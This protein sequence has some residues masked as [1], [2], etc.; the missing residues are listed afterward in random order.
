M[1]RL[2]ALIFLASLGCTRVTADDGCRID[3]NTVPCG[4]ASVASSAY[5]LDCTIWQASAGLEQSPTSLGWIG[6]WSS[7]VAS[8][9]V[10]SKVNSAKLYPNGTF[11]SL[12]GT[13]ATSASADFANFFYVEDQ[14]RTGGIRIVLPPNSVSSLTRCSVVNVFGTVNSSTTGERQLIGCV[15]TVTGSSSPIAPVLMANVAVGGGN[16]GIVPTGQCGVTNGT[17]L[18]NVGQLVATS[19]RVQSTGG[20][21]LYIDDGSGPVMIDCTTLTNPPALNSFVSV[22]GISSL[23]R[24]GRNIIRLILPRNDL[25]VCTR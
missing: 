15:A 24:S 8:P 2:V 17:G 20:G 21:Y 4:G 22:V 7:D 13:I 25:D 5:K 1:A 14:D 10:L 18:N 11:V 16:Y 23:Y 6:F 3:W 19:G 12:V 9:S